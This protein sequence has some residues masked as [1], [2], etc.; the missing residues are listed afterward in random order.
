LHPEGVWVINQDVV[1]AMVSRGGRPDLA[2][3][4]LSLVA[5]PTLFIGGGNDDRLIALNE[6]PMTEVKAI[7]KMAI[8]SGATQLFE[9]PGVLESFADLASYWFL[10]YLKKNKCSRISIR[11]RGVSSPP[12]HRMP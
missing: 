12:K 11:F 7:K 2:G 1:R 6:R 3:R 8:V 5:A 9:E 10:K 4:A